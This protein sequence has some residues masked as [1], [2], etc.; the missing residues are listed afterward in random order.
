LRVLLFTVL[1]SALPG[2]ALAELSG[3]VVAV[4]DGDSLTLEVQGRKVRVRL[5]GIDAPEPGQRFGKS[6]TRSL[7][8]ICRGKEAIV[9]DRGKDEEGRVVGSVTCGGVD[10]NAEQVK[11]GMAWVFR[12]YLPLGSPLY[13]L[14]SNARLRG[15]GLWRDSDPVPP[16]EWRKKQAAGR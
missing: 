4:H 11:R 5:D 2:T 7:A 6:A 14:E 16:W 8:N 15:L 3:R 9:N 12:T 13:E 1:C 10:A